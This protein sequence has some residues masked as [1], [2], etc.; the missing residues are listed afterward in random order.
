MDMHSS[1]TWQKVGAAGI[2]TVDLAALRRNYR[3]IADMVAPS[4]AGAVVKANAYGLGAE[5]VAQ[6]L[7]AEGCRTFFVAEYGE[8]VALRARLSRSAEIVVLNG[9]QPGAEADCAQRG[10]I[11]VLNSLEQTARWRSIATLCSDGLPALLQVDTGMA[12]LGMSHA[13][14]ASLAANP[15]MLAGIRL[16]YI[17]S[18]LGCADETE[19]PHNHAQAQ[20]MQRISALFPTIPL[21]FGNSGGSFLGE[22]FRGALVRPGIALYGGRST[23]RPGDTVEPVVRVEGAIIQTRLVDDGTAVGY[24]ASHTT[25]GKRRLATV[26]LGYADGIL[27]ALSNRGA[28]YAGAQRLP[29]VGR[30]SMDSTIIDITDLEGEDLKLG[31]LVE[32][33]GPHQSLEAVAAW[34]DTISWEVLTSLG[35]RYQRHYI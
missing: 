1:Q 29:I 5:H 18:H 11:P 28:F 2:L 20:E 3:R 16:R 4:Q 24:S 15:G 27:R 13:E 32:F 35:A 31:S 30:V 9:L 17:M 23:D 10:I 6:A 33:I 25:T 34:A 14:A 26:S 19:H 8:A 22:A 12:R 21:S 7:F